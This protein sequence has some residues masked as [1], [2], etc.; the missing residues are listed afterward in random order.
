[1][2]YRFFHPYHHNN[3]YMVDF[4]YLLLYILLMFLPVLNPTVHSESF[5]WRTQPLQQVHYLVLVVTLVDAVKTQQTIGFARLLYAHRFDWAV[6]V[7]ASLKALFFVLS[8]FS[9]LKFIMSIFLPL[10]CLQ[11]CIFSPYFNTLYCSFLTHFLPL[12]Y[13]P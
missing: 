12:F 8:H 4:S 3:N 6:V 9:F 2:R 10:P 7:L 1:M 13:Y 11:K 5:Y